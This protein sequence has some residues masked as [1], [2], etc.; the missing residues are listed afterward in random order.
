MMKWSLAFSQS[1][2]VCS[3]PQIVRRQTLKTIRASRVL[4]YVV[5]KMAAL[6]H[7]ETRKT[8]RYFYTA[9]V[10]L[11][12]IQMCVILENQNGRTELNPAH[13]H[14][15]TDINQSNNSQYNYEEQGRRYD[16][17]HDDPIFPPWGMWWEWNEHYDSFESLCLSCINWRQL[18]WPSQHNYISI[19]AIRHTS[20]ETHEHRTVRFPQS[21]TDTNASHH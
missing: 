10:L 2:F 15:R 8:S 9:V 5:H 6:I 17:E 16:T 11:L 4:E 13:T 19:A 7:T 20:A 18:L 12:N 1:M 14:T 3:C 21:L